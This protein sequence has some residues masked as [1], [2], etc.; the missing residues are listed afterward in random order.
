MISAD[1]LFDLRGKIA[2]VTGASRG[3]GKAIAEGL[4]G[5][6]CNLAMVSRTP[7]R[8]KEVADGLSTKYE[9]CT[10]PL[11]ADVSVP[12]D[13]EAM[14]KAT[15]A[16]FDRIDILVNNAGIMLRR[17]ALESPFEEWARVIDVNLK[18]TFL[19]SQ[20][21]GRVMKKQGYG[22]IINM[23]SVRAKACVRE[24]LTAYSSSKGGINSLTKSLACEL[25]E[26]N[27]NVNAIAP[28]FF[29]TDMNDYMFEDEKFVEK[30]RTTIPLG[31]SGVGDD[32]IGPVAFFASEASDFVTGQILYIDGGVTV[33]SSF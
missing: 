25:A 17:K 3:L 14:A 15:E 33:L 21:I 16:H 24:G 13:V 11:I 7:D 28:T 8:L 12:A 26:Y 9:V 27:I 23:S 22:K 31:R 6:G 1:R 32:L 29:R 4:A 10:L 19:C 2:V 18:G 30:L 5:L 20:A